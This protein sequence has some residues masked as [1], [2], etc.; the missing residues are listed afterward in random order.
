MT[1][2]YACK[3]RLN[4]WGNAQAGAILCISGTK[5]EALQEIAKYKKD[6][7]VLPCNLSNAEEENEIAR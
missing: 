2:F 1:P 6:V 5:K 4:P 3:R 7:Y